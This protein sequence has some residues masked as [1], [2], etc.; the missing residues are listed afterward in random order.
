MARGDGETVKEALGYSVRFRQLKNYS[1]WILFADF[2]G[3]AADD[4]EISLR[5]VDIF[6]EVD[7]KREENVVGI[8]RVTVGELDSLA[9]NERVGEAIGRDF[10]GFGER[11]FRQLSGAIDMDKIGLHYGDQFAGAGVDGDQGIQRFWLAA[12]RNDQT[13]SGMAQFARKG[14]EFFFGRFLLRTGGSRLRQDS[15]KRQ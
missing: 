6:V 1:L 13:A 8:Q 11:G 12:K 4:E 15:D 5:S 7:A 3:L 10:P 2:D 9:K 14:E